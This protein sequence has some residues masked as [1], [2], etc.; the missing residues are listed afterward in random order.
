MTVSRRAAEHGVG[1]RDAA[2]EVDPVLLLDA[3]HEAR[4]ARDVGEQQVPLA[5]RR[6]RPLGD[7]DFLSSLHVPPCQAPWTKGAGAPGGTRT[8]GLLLRRQTLYP[9]SYGRATGHRVRVN[10]RDREGKS[11]R[12]SRRR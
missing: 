4:V 10:A 8:H 9:L 2:A 6:V 3:G 5:R 11:A 1:G 7:P 12:S